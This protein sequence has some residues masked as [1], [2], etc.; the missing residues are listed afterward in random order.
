MFNYVQRLGKSLLLPIATLPVCAIL[1]G[2][3]YIL[4]PASMG[5]GEVVTGPAYTIG[6][7]LTTCGS[8]LINN[9]AILFAIGV[10]VGMAKKNDGAA[11]I[12]ALVSWLILTTMLNVENVVKFIEIDDI[13][14]IAFKSVCNPFIGILAGIIGSSCFNKFSGIKLPDFLAFF[15]G[16][17]FVAIVATAITFLVSVLLLFIWPYVFGGLVAFGN[18]ITNLEGIGVGVYQ[19]ANRML[20]PVGLHHALNNVFWFDTIGIGDLTNF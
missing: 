20:I 6:M 14:Q 15:G 7:L 18:L 19:F 17:R 9:M 1:L 10:G 16:K 2:I 12:A 3:G 5:A 13:A 4:A 11:A 8:A